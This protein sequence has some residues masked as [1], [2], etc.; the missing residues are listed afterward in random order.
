VVGRRRSVYRISDALFNFWFRFV[1]P[2]RDEIEMGFDVVEDIKEE[3]NEYLGLAFEGIA[4]QFLVR[5][6]MDGKLPFR[7]TRIG[8]WWRKGEEIDLVA[9]NERERK[10]L[11]VEVKWKD[12]SERE[13][14]GILKDLERK[15]ELVG[16]EEWEKHYG[17]VAKSVEGKEELKEEGYLAWDLGDFNRSS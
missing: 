13:A 2:R 10:A 15:A 1:F 5:L 4:K 16:L 12:L 7:F 9:L 14:R 11:F 3:F 8:R 6:N 17:L